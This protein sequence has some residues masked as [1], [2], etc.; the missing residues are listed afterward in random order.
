[1]LVSDTKMPT[2]GMEDPAITWNSLRQTGG[3][4]LCVLLLSPP[5]TSICIYLRIDAPKQI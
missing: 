1:M 4:T 3:E 2:R 5:K